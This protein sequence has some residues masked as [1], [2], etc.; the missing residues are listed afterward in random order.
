MIYLF[1]VIPSLHNTSTYRHSPVNIN[2]SWND[3]HLLS[4]RKNSRHKMET[5][6]SMSCLE[7]K[8]LILYH[9][10]SV[11]KAFLS[12]SISRTSAFTTNLENC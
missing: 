7:N 10:Q 8:P 1:G 2:C 6:T 4:Y 3:L 9:K 5:L 12:G 11:L